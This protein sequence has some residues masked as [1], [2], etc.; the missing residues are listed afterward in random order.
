MAGSIFQSW[1]ISVAVV[2]LCFVVVSCLHSS[3]LLY[4]PEIS[5][6]YVKLFIHLEVFVNATLLRIFLPL[7]SVTVGQVW[8]VCMLPCN[9]EVPKWSSEEKHKAGNVHLHK[10]IHLCYQYLLKI[11]L[12]LHFKKHLVQ[13]V[14]LFDCLVSVYVSV[15]REKKC[16]MI[17]TYCASSFYSV[18]MSKAFMQEFACYLRF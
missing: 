2:L 5:C 10:Y 14:W 3:C 8:I 6:C 1:R 11:L 15:Q 17:N 9:R 18:T 16:S 13:R 4:K 12:L 7:T